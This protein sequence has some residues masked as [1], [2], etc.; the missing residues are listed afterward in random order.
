MAEVRNTLRHIYSLLTINRGTFIKS[1]KAY[2]YAVAE[3][4]KD[5]TGKKF[6]VQTLYERKHAL[7]GWAVLRVREFSSIHHE[8]NVQLTTFIHYLGQT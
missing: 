4:T 5:G 3:Q 6:R 1:C 7:R 2:L 8:W